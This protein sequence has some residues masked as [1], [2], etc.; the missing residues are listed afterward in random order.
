[1]LLS[2][3]LLQEGNFSSTGNLSISNMKPFQGVLLDKEVGVSV[4]ISF[5]GQLEIQPH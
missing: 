4:I 2:L 3:R 1:M 5:K